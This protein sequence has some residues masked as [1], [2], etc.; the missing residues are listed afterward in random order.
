MNQLSHFAINADD[1]D[2]ARRFYEAV[3]GW[4]F[5]PF[6]PPGFYRIH[7]ADGKPPGPMGALQQRRELVPG[8]SMSGFE[9]TV[10]VDDVDAVARAVTASGGR[11]VM[12]KTAIAGVGELIFFEDPEGN[13]AGAMRYDPGAGLRR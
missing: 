6:G 12:D 1:V 5:Q 10:A 11:V 9:C 7:T 13:L 2:R 4:T 8:R 3:F